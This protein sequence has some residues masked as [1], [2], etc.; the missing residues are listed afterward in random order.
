MAIV[1]YT[2]AISVTSHNITML[3]TE[4]SNLYIDRITGINRKGEEVLIKHIGEFVN[5]SIAFIYEDNYR[6]FNIYY[7]D[8]SGNIDNAILDLNLKFVSSYSKY[9]KYGS[10]RL[11]EKH[12]GPIANIKPV[13]DMANIGDANISMSLFVRLYDENNAIIHG[14]E[15]MIPLSSDSVMFDKSKKERYSSIYGYIEDNKINDE[16]LLI[17]RDDIFVFGIPINNDKYIKFNNEIVSIENINASY[18]SLSGVINIINTDFSKSNHTPIIKN[19]NL[20]TYS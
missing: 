9:S 1:K 5:N 18:I 14:Y 17:D 2:K 15:V 11:K 3:N 6:I 4:I 7:D 20:V 12:I 10:I 13:V 8:D 16:S 19:I